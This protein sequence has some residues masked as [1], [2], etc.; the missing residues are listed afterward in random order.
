MRS[1]LAAHDERVKAAIAVHGGYVFSPGGDGFGAAFG[2]AADAVAAALQ[3]QADI[4]DLPDISA[5]MAI[6][7]GA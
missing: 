6:N 1:A 7:T 4:A 5:R 3:A 2:T